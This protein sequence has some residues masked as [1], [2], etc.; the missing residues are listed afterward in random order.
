[1]ELGLWGWYIR[2]VPGSVPYIFNCRDLYGQND[3][4]YPDGQCIRNPGRLHY[5]GFGC[6]YNRHYN[7]HYNRD[8]NRYANNNDNNLRL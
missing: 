8:H 4:H 6:N 7:C 5:G 1:M 2:Y 3:R